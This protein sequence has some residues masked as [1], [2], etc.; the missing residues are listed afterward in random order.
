MC[1]FLNNDSILRQA[2]K[3]VVSYKLV[4]KENGKYS[5]RYRKMPIELGIMYHNPDFTNAFFKVFEQR[6]NSI[7]ELNAGGFHSFVRIKDAKKVSSIT[8]G[9][10]IACIIPQG[11]MYV[12]GTWDDGE[13]PMCYFSEASIYRELTLLERLKLT[14]CKKSPLL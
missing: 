6:Y 1:T 13:G 7:K 5:S 10:V 14:F 12:N 9:E 8:G 3:D 11:S 4:N 2:D